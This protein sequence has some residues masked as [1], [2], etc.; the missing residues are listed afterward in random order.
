M[1]WHEIYDAV[2]KKIISKCPTSMHFTVKGFVRLFLFTDLFGQKITVSLPWSSL[3]SPSSSSILPLSALGERLHSNF[4]EAG[5]FDSLG[6]LMIRVPHVS[7]LQ[8]PHAVL[9]PLLGELLQVL[10][11]FKLVN[12]VGHEDV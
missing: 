7:L 5:F 1:V 4:I 6:I 3:L 11:L 12:S 10:L 9:G 2:D 8:Q